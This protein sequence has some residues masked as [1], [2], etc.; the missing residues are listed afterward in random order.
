MQWALDEISMR[1]MYL[2][3]KRLED[4]ENF[5]IAIVRS[6]QQQ[7]GLV[8]PAEARTLFAQVP[9]PPWFCF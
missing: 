9:V 1:K 6:V 8:Q 4:V 2:S 3:S 7:D 5:L